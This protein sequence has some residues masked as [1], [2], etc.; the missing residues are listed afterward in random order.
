MEDKRPYSSI[1]NSIKDYL[2][3]K[4]I[5]YVVVAQRLEMSS[6]AVSKQL[7]GKIPFG[8]SSAEKWASIFPFNTEFL[9]YG[10]G[11]LVKEAYHFNNS[12]HLLRYLSTES[13]SVIADK[14]DALLKIMEVIDLPSIKML[15]GRYAEIDCVYTNDVKIDTETLKNEFSVYKSALEFANSLNNK[16]N[17]HKTPIECYLEFLSKYHTYFLHDDSDLI[18]ALNNARKHLE[19]NRKKKKL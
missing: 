5:S 1:C 15:I 8:R 10:T 3:E 11:D 9:L 7:S 18:P 19:E 16:W 6:S 17:L 13:P 4:G 2:Q 12:P 14:F